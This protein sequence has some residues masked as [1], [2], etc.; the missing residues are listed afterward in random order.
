MSR[1]LMV[2][3]DYPPIR[4]GISSLAFHLASDLVR[5]G[6]EVEVVAPAW[7]GAREQDRQDP[8]RVFRTPGYGLGY[9][10]GLPLLAVA[11]WR[12]LARPP[13]LVLPMNVAYGGLAMLLLRALGH[14]VP[15]LMFAYG[16]EF[17]RFQGSPSMRRLYRRVYEGARGIFA[18]SADTRRRL[19]DFGVRHP[20][21][22]MYPGVEL[23]RFSPDGPDFR[24]DLSL[25]GRPVLASISR[26]V[27]RKGHDLVIRALPRILA[28]LPDAVYLVVG[29]G[30][31]RARLERLAGDLGVASSTR[32]V[33]EVED[34]ALA[35]WFRTCDVFVL[36]SREIRRSGHVEGFGIV[37]LEAGA[38]GRAV[39][40]GR[41]GGVVEAV[42]DGRTGLLVDPEDPDDLARALLVLLEDPAAA[43]A[44]GA[45]GRRRV[46]RSFT[47]E[48]A[49]AP[50]SDF[51]DRPL[52]VGPQV[53]QRR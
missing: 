21:E 51:A 14:R 34:D 49:L 2:T 16:L 44:M 26:L 6:H 25:E 11:A 5:R 3:T 18:V 28:A 27:E 39:V 41:S 43:R 9:L 32:F 1:I 23:S 50:C 10:R 38:C 31:D 36:P 15:Y 4:G 53:G 45:A 29:D 20:V 46:E 47:W 24:R 37:F 48:R 22:V 35:A 13:H 7:T 33:G 8:C 40:G 52:E 12:L 42:D 17:A 30:P 19:E